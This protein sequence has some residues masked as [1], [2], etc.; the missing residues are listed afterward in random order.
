MKKWL[1]A[2]VS[3]FIVTSGLFVNTAIPANAGSNMEESDYTITPFEL[4]G[5]AHQGMLSKQGIPGYAGLRSNYQQENL[6]AK[7]LVKAAIDS[8]RLS[9]SAMNDEDYLASVET[10]LNA[11]DNPSQN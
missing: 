4:V 2:G 8:G 10:Q 3:T 9:D 7:D 6:H 5:L 11:L 1:A